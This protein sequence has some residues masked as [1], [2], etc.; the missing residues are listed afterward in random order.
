MHYS[1][2]ISREIAHGASHVSGSSE[3]PVSAYANLTFDQCAMHIHYTTVRVYR[4][5][6][7]TELVT[8]LLDSVSAY[9]NLTFDHRTELV[10]FQYPV[11]RPSIVQRVHHKSY[12][13]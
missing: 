7:H 10:T 3:P 6:T 4:V 9:A 12:L 5:E 11:Q 1:A 8:S 13:R 2:C